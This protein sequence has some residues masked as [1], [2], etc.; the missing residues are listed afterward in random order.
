MFKVGSTA[1]AHTTVYEYIIRGGT[2][3][4]VEVSI[5]WNA[6]GQQIINIAC[7]YI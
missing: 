1:V 6:L 7:A 5:S 2:T 3:A 4:V